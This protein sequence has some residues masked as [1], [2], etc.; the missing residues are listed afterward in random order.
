MFPSCGSLLQHDQ[1]SMFEQW[2]CLA[3]I[4]NGYIEHAIIFLTLTITASQL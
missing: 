3:K 2:Q 4:N 1:Q